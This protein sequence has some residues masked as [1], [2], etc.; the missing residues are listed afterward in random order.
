MKKLLCACVVLFAL[1][2]S[3]LAAT[4][5]NVQQLLTLGNQLNV[6][7]QGME[8]QKPLAGVLVDPSIKGASAALFGLSES[9]VALIKAPAAFGPGMDLSGLK[10]DA[11]LPLYVLLGTDADAIWATAETVLGAMPELIYAV[12][13]GQTAV[14]GAT[15]DETTGAVTFIGTHPNLLVLAGQHILGVDATP[16][17]EEAPAAEVPAEDKAHAAEAAAP[18]AK[19]EVH[20]AA[21]HAE[22]T[23]AHAPAAEAPAAHGAD[24]AHEAPAQGGGL[25]AFGILLFI[26]A[27]IGTVIFMDKTVLKP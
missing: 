23:P 20:A 15:M 5:D 12:M 2:S 6:L 8:A 10:I 22:E 17:T 27:L 24:A 4:P 1:T 25:G 16:A 7:K 19:E 21:A 13:K 3:A 26:A 14:L 11:T 18:A 9:Q